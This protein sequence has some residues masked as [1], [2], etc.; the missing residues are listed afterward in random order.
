[1]SNEPT[2]TIER[3]FNAPR[4]LVWKA[5]TDPKLFPQ[6]FGPTKGSECK[7]LAFEL[8]VGG[9]LH[10]EI[11]SPYGHMYGKFTYQEIAPKSKLSWLHSFAD[12][13]GNVIQAP[14]N[15][16]WPR[17]LLTSIYFEDAGDKTHLKLTWVPVKPTDA[18]RQCFADGLSGMS[19]GWGGTFGL[20]EE[21]LAKKNAA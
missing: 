21:F 18:E 6:W 12:E 19:Q 14:H 13:K 9:V 7:V 11:N 8:K 10:S 16:N 2:F 5:W 20:L 17:E 4:D 1:M 3:I 15:T